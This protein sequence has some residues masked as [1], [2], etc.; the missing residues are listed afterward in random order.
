[1]VNYI[2]NLVRAY[3]NIDAND[4]ATL[5]AKYGRG[6]SSA[7]RDIIHTHCVELRHQRNQHVRHTD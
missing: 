1:M 2:G 5:E 4:K 6:W 3:I 7:V